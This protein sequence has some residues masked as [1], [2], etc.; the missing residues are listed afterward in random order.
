MYDLVDRLD[1]TPHEE[2]PERE[3]EAMRLRVR[4]AAGEEALLYQWGS[5]RAAARA[6]RVFGGADLGDQLFA[7]PDLLDGDVPGRWA[8]VRHPEGEPLTR[9]LEQRGAASLAALDPTR[10]RAMCESLGVLLRKLH[11]LDASGLFGEIPPPGHDPVHPGLA[12]FHTFNGW[13]A[14]RLERYAEALNAHA[15][16]DEEQRLSCRQYLGDLRHELSAFHPRHAASLQHGSLSEDHL[17]ISP[18]GHEVVALTGFERAR[19]LPAEADLAHLLW[20][21][22]MVRSDEGS[23]RALY[24]GYGAA[25]TMDVQRRERFY[26]RLAAFDILLAGASPRRAIP[27]EELLALAGPAIEPFL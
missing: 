3:G 13:V 15:T 25:R 21:E 2:A 7:V 24:R 6:I 22:G 14:G 1:V 11:S 5:E 10:A 26:R 18:S 23:L 19:Y 4:T 17:W 27:S 9:F 8:L 20:I 12:T 16:L